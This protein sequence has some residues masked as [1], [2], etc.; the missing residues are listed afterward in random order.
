[1]EK[2]IIPHI[3]TESLPSTDHHNPLQL[4]DEQNSPPPISPISPSA[5]ILFRRPF[6]SR[7][8]FKAGHRLFKRTKSHEHLAS[9]SHAHTKR[10]YLSK[11][12]RRFLIWTGI[13][14]F[15]NWRYWTGAVNQPLV[16]NIV[17]MRCPTWPIGGVIKEGFESVG[18]A[19]W[20]NFQ[21]G[22][23]VGASFVAYVGE[24]PVVDL[25]G[26]YHSRL[27]K[28]K[29]TNESLQIVFSS[30]KAVEGIAIAYLVD[31]GKLDYNERIAAYWPEFAQGNKE[32]VTLAHLLGHRAGVTYLDNDNQPTLQEISDLDQMAELLARQ[33]HNFNGSVVQGYQAV[34]RGW[35]LN[36]I[37]RRVDGRTLGQIIRQ[38]IMPGLDVEFY[39]GLPQDKENRVSPIMGYPALRTMA[40][41]LLPSR[42]Q[43]EP[44]PPTVRRALFDS[45]SISY[46]ATRGSSP[47]QI[48]PWP[49]SHNR[50]EV[51]ASEGPSYGGITNAKSLARLAAVMANGG[52][53]DG[54]TLI[55]NHSTMRSTEIPLPRLPDVVLH[56]NLTFATGGW[57]LDVRFPEAEDIGWG[58]KLVLFPCHTWA[59]AGGSMI[60]W[61]QERRIAFSYVMNSA[62]FGTTGDKRSHRLISEL[63]KCLKNISDGRKAGGQLKDWD[64]FEF[65]KRPV[66]VA[67]VVPLEDASLDKM[68]VDVLKEL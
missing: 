7:I 51:W 15:V 19:F 49:H 32:N 67:P 35:Y 30:S 53:F 44:L 34:T 16:C 52:S 17:G 31:R 12:I 50:R 68:P 22:Y 56:R 23:E 29:Y 11:G 2:P 61:N 60:W 21:D 65:G 64:E 38:D 43:T 48:R 26:G 47:K 54:F 13:L 37:A 8:L 62:E 45:S 57:A 20:Q 28:R 40:K 9:H 66:K 36:E 63:V 59:G 4:N 10:T 25:F 1:M 58:K 39:L 24:E 27:F 46:K 33:P 3:R 42:F 18:E 5:S 41:L 6:R 55:K 14:S